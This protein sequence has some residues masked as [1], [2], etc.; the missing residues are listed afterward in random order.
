MRQRKGASGP[1]RRVDFATN[2]VV[3][4][5]HNLPQGVSALPV[6]EEYGSLLRR[7]KFV[8]EIRQGEHATIVFGIGGISSIAQETIVTAIGAMKPQA[9]TE[10]SCLVAL[11]GVLHI[12]CLL[13][14]GPVIQRIIEPVGKISAKLSRYNVIALLGSLGKEQISIRPFEPVKRHCSPAG[15]VQIILVPAQGKASAVA[16]LINHWLVRGANHAQMSV[17]IGHQAC[18]IILMKTLQQAIRISSFFVGIINIK[19]ENPEGIRR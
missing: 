16:T 15:I 12:L 7:G 14:D 9:R 18:R 5:V 2:A 17:I 3:L 1:P 10:R 13:S 6:I 11:V 8:S 4:R 19:N